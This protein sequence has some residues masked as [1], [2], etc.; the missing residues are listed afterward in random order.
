MADTIR[1]QTDISTFGWHLVLQDA[2]GSLAYHL[3][4]QW[5]VIP[6][7]TVQL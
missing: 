3:S 5:L 7:P 2:G 1:N 4:D 6:M